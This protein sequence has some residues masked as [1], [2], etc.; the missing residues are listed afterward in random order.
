MKSKNK[1]LTALAF[2]GLLLSAG[3]IQAATFGFADIPLSNY[4]GSGANTSG[5]VIDFND[6]SATERYVFAYE[7]DGVVG[8]VSGFAML[9]AV[10]T[11]LPELSFTL[12]GGSIENGGFLANITFGSQ[13]QTSGDFVTNFDFW[14]YFIA[15]GVSGENEGTPVAIP[16]AG[17]VIPEVLDSAPTGASAMSFGSPGRFIADGSWDV[18]SFGPYETTYV[19]PEP[20][21]FAL[22]GGLFA[23]LV[24]YRRRRAIR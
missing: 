11:A 23:L 16:G 24:V 12:G 17:V 10:A 14:G 15:G 8:D 9:D 6:G 18:W 5:L 22:I 21:N 13:T 1:A 2:A 3:Q 4:V 20:S 19:V 7:W